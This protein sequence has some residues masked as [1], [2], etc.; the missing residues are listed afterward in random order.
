MTH[1]KK[2]FGCERRD[3]EY[4]FEVKIRI[5]LFTHLDDGE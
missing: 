2:L 4:V 5:N 1:E 3:Q